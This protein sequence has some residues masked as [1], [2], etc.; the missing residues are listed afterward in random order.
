MASS[1]SISNYPEQVLSYHDSVLYASDVALIEQ[2]NWLN[3]HCILFWFQV[4]EYDEQVWLDNESPGQGS[5]QYKTVD[6]LFLQ[7][8]SAFMIQFLSANEL[9]VGT[10]DNVFLTI[11]DKE[12]VFIPVVGNADMN[13]GG[14]SHWSLLVYHNEKFYHLD[15]SNGSNRFTARSLASRFISLL[16][17]VK[18]LNF[19]TINSAPQQS[20]SYDC[21]VFV[22]ANAEYIAANY[23]K[24]GKL[25][26]P[27]S[28]AH[29]VGKRKQM[30]QVIARLSA[31]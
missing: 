13:A 5:Q 27:T 31:E 30:L 23:L 28:D 25:V 29:V 2:S 3:D 16:S 4:L 9:L 22:L 1:K 12:L 21:G 10:E 6:I 14:G 18:N 19:L 20:N 7:P 15:S 17:N 11:K 24:S 8:A 26:F